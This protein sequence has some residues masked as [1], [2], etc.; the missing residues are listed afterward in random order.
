MKVSSKTSFI[1]LGTLIIGIIIGALGSGLMQQK[2]IEKI[3]RMDPGQRFKKALFDIIKA[4]KAQQQAIEKILKEQ[5]AKIAQLD[6]DYQ[7]EI[8]TVF[9]STRMKIKSILTEKQ[10]QQFEKGIYKGHKSFIARRLKHMRELL[11]LSDEQYEK[12]EKILRQSKTQKSPFYFFSNKSNYENRQH[13]RD[14]L[15]K[16]IESILTPE[17]IEKYKEMSQRG[18]HNYKRHKIH[19]EE[20]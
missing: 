7:S 14:S 13:S 18:R 8:F 12:I 4:D 10:L 11:E 2:R 19:N 9:D 15:M 16:K 3:K 20:N 6:D 17:Q 5:T 1:L